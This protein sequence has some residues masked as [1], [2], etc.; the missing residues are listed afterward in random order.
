MAYTTI[1]KSTDYFNTILYTGTGNTGQGQTGVGFQPDMTWIKCRSHAQSHMVQDAVR[2]A[3]KQ[4]FPNTNG[5]ETSWTNGLTSF[6]S[7]GFTVAGSDEGGASSK[8]Y[9][10][11]NWKANGAGSANTDGSINTTSTSVNTTAGFSI[12]KYTGTGSNATVGHGLGKVPKV[13]IF[14]KLNS[15]D[16]WF[17]YHEPLGNT[18]RLLLSTNDA[19]ATSAGY[20]NST[21]PTSSVFS[22]GTN[23]GNN[24]SGDD[25]VAYCWSEIYGFS[26]FGSYLGN[27]NADGS[28]IYTGFNP[29]MVIIKLYS[30]GSENWRIFDNKRI[31]YNPNNYKLYPSLNNTEGTSDLIDLYSNG[32]KPRSTSVEFNG[33]GNGYIYM[34]FGQS[35][36]GSNNVP[37]TAR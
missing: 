11:W 2:G 6:D 18:K 34:A 9:V 30:T 15:S 8:T 20:F 21:T 7:D 25:Y 24:Q 31:G 27:G 29:A 10:A 3:T 12:S 37:C 33:S 28:F 14:K 23:G 22:L 4:I 32:F 13:I 17:N 16:N 36:V 1:N 5:A 19:E 35:L 26:K